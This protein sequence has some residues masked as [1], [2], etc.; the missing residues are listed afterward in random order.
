M[1][2]W[3]QLLVRHGWMVEE[4]NEDSFRFIDESEENIAFLM[5]SLE[6]LQIGY[7]NEADVIIFNSTPV[8]EEALLTVLDFEF[9]GRTELIGVQNQAISKLDTYIAGIVRQLNRL[10]YR[11]ISS[12]DGHTR[13]PAHILV[14][15]TENVSQL[16]ELLTLFGVDVLLREFS[17]HDRFVFRM[18]RERLL[19]VAEQLATI[20]PEML[21]GN[22]ENVKKKTFYQLVEELLQVPGKSGNE[23][24]IR[25][26]V[27]EKMT[28][29]IDQLTVD[30]SGNILAEKT[31]RSGNGPTILLNAHL[32]I[33]E[34]PVAGRK[35]V[36]EGDIWRS[37][38]GILGADDRAGVAAVLWVAQQLL[39]SE[40]SGKVKY[41]F[42]VEEEIGLLGAQ[43]VADYFL[44][45]IDAAF[46]VDRRGTGDIVTSAWGTIPFCADEL[47]KWLESVA[48]DAGLL[49]WESTSGGSSDTKIWA[50]HG[51]Q[52][53][54]L[55]A[56]YSNEHTVEE[57]LDVAACYNVTEFLLAIFEQ[58]RELR[59]LVRR[60]QRENGNMRRAF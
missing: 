8:K 48:A 45:G 24:A 7:Q 54:N 60:L 52:S 43:R 14:E 51:I 44:W 59:R 18:E 23:E 56:G 10:G 33:V 1:K 26:V 31:Y 53:V 6:T 55:S 41:I 28:P 17:L 57:Y 16:K 27:M 35:I 30:A 39:H 29:F 38:E 37:D 5:K 46:V 3:K 11:T 42:T 40:F 36:I 20:S 49:G 13:V 12:C 2:T 32:D 4:L 9:R 25:H 50:E 58:S 47:G 22:M 15:K 19:D 21:R 34:E